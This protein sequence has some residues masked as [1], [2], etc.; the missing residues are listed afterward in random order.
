MK[1]RAILYCIWRSLFFNA[2]IIP[3]SMGCKLAFLS[4]ENDHLYI[5]QPRKLFEIEMG[6]TS[7]EK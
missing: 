7:I 4:G 2:E 5:L 3:A 6:A 1:L